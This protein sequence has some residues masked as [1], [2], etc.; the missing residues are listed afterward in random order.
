MKKLI[1]ILAL[2]GGGYF[3]GE[4]KVYADTPA[5]CSPDNPCVYTG[6]VA[7]RGGGQ[8]VS[9]KVYLKELGG[10]YV[11]VVEING[12]KATAYAVEDEKVHNKYHFT[13][14]DE[15]YDFTL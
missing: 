7:P 10:R 4:N 8:T 9:I 14:E 15:V 6:K 12:G 5:I 1:L 3:V 11:Y 2:L 13:Y